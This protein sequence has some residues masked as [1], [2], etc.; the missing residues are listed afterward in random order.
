MPWVQ[1]SLLSPSYKP[2]FFALFL[3]LFCGLGSFEFELLN[4]DTRF[5]DGLKVV[6]WMVSIPPLLMLL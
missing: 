6:M 2:H 1:V 5:P 4:K 3:L